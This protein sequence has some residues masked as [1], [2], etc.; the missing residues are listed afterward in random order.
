MDKKQINNFAIIGA[1]PVG[2]FLSYLLVSKGKTVSL[3][4][5]G[6]FGIESDALNLSKYIFQTKSKIPNGVHMVGGA[7]NLWHGRISEFSKTAFNRIDGN[8][9]REWPISEEKID[10]AWGQFWDLIHPSRQ[11]DLE[12]LTSNYYAAMTNIGENLELKLY[13]F[14][15]PDYF[16]RLLNELLKSQNFKI[17]TNSTCLKVEH[18]S[19]N[20]ND[21]FVQ[22][23]VKN[24]NASETT[25][26]RHGAVILTG[27]CMQS[28]ALILRSDE[29]MADLTNSS[30]VGSN[31]MEHFD[32]YVGTLRTTNKDS[33][34]LRN[35]VMGDDR[36][37]PG[38]YFGIGLTLKTKTTDLKSHQPDFHLEIVSW[39][40]T[41]LFDPNL[42]IFHGLK[43]Y[44]YKSFFFLE[45]ALRFFPGKMRSIWYRIRGIEIYS[46]WLKG[47]EFANQD[48]TLRVP[49]SKDPSN[50]ELVYDHRVSKYSKIKMKLVLAYI[51]KELEIQNLGKFRM[52]KY[53]HFNRFFYTG[54]NFHPMGTLRMGNDSADSVTSPDFSIHG[55]PR[56]FVMNSG[57]F[58][59]GSNQNPTAMVLALSIILAESLAGENQT[60][61]S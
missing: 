61:R 31:L 29:I 38:K 22:V 32:G 52:H 9:K 42:N 4:E 14:C 17:F 34:K 20:S 53:F 41:Y 55:S 8:G 59:N 1:G 40:K 35:L 2:I 49:G 16:R 28:T 30:L 50:L 13:R 47:E 39:R 48:S 36:R 37:I 27:G 5:A 54:P 56:V 24:S 26:R 58:P 46:V 33:N 43:P 25:I 15:D 18:L 57:I 7:S 51:S 3:Y 44:Q 10:E 23:I 19:S 6:G 11:R 12:F 45:R 60:S 21:E